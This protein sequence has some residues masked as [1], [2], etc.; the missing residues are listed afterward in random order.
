MSRVYT[1]DD[2]MA[3]NPGS[4]GNYPRSWAQELIGDQGK[5]ARE[6]AQLDLPVQ[7]RLWLLVFVCMQK[8]HIQIFNDIFLRNLPALETRARSIIQEFRY[9]YVKT[10]DLWALRWATYHAFPCRGEIQCWEYRK[11]G[12]EEE[13]EEPVRAMVAIMEERL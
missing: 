9:A 13:Y 11:I 12:R 8:H 6:I 5:T 10:D 7:E 1:V 3:A 4:C 2:I